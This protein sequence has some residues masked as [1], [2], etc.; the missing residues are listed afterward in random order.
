MSSSVD[1]ITPGVADSSIGR[2][3]VCVDVNV[4]RAHPVDAARRLLGA[5][6]HAGDVTVR[7]VEVEAYGGP[8]VGPWPDP[9]AHSFRGSTPRNS[10]MFGPAG[11]AY[12]YVSYGM[13]FCMNVSCGPDGEA[14]GVLLRA[15]EVVSGSDIVRLRRGE[16][17]KDPRLASGPGNLGRALGITLEDNGTNLLDASSRMQLIG[18]T[19]SEDSLEIAE[20]PRVGVSTAA[21]RAWRL[22]I[23]RSPAVSQYRRSPRAPSP[24]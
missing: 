2:I 11:R 4:L 15:A 8:D 22:W 6:L 9:A 23:P 12:V 10:V 7:I 20:G 18:R 3:I 17:T 24:Q 14:A 13:H 19:A 1:E 21:D 5:E 16:Q